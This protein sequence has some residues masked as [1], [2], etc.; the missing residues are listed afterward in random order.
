[1]IV[2][3]FSACIISALVTQDVGLISSLDVLAS[4]S[5]NHRGLIDTFLLVSCLLTY[6]L[7]VSYVNYLILML[8]CFHYYSRRHCTMHLFLSVCLSVCPHNKTKTAKTKIAKLGTEIVHHNFLI[9]PA[10]S[11]ISFLTQNG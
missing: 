8:N 2:C 11:I 1:M 4:L 6:E 10:A 3:L 7:S 5:I 9:Q